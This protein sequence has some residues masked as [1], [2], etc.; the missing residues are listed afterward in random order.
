MSELI[1]KCEKLNKNL[2]QAIASQWK[3]CN[4]T[5][6]K[7]AMKQAEKEYRKINQA[8]EKK[9]IKKIETEKL[10]NWYGKDVK[11]QEMSKED[12]KE[13][14]NMLSEFV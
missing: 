6:V 10:P 11:K 14:E 2:V 12:I 3:M 13:L 9:N 5:T 8:K 4:I 7:D 1:L